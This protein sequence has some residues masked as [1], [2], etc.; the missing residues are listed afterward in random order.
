MGLGQLFQS[1]ELLVERADAAFTGM[2]QAH[3][4]CIRCKRSCSNCCHAVFGLF[5]IEAAYLKQQFDRL[6]SE[7]KRTALLMCDE[8]DR[9]VRRL[10]KMLEGHDND[11]RM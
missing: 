1:Y 3:G 7:E 9:A 6:M 4:E 11:P 5:L 8:A 10:Q 2:D